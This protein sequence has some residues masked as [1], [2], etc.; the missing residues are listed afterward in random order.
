MHFLSFGKPA[1]AG[2]LNRDCL[3]SGMPVYAIKSIDHHVQV[4]PQPSRYVVLV[5]QTDPICRKDYKNVSLSWIAG[6][7]RK[8]RSQAMCTEYAF[9]L[10]FYKQ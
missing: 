7:A 3:R 9:L 4:A 8:H 2:Y 1:K 6:T 10:Y 5:V